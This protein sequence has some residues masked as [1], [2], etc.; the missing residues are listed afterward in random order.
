M[1]RGFA[2]AFALASLVHGAAAAPVGK[3]AVLAAGSRAAAAYDGAAA[4]ATGFGNAKVGNADDA[5]TLGDFGDGNQLTAG[6]SIYNGDKYLNETEDERFPAPAAAPPPDDSA[7]KWLTCANEGELCE[8]LGDNKAKIIRY[9]STGETSMYAD[10]QAWFKEHPQVVKWDYLT[11]EDHED[12]ALCADL[13]FMHRDPFPGHDKVCQCA[14]TAADFEVLPP[15]PPPPPWQKD[16]APSPPPLSPGATPMP[17]PSPDPWGFSWAKC[18]DDGELCTCAPGSMVRYGWTGNEDMYRN[19]S[20]WFKEHPEVVRWVYKDLESRDSSITCSAKEFP[21]PDDPFYGY[22][23]HCQCAESALLTAPEVVIPKKVIPPPAPPA[24]AGEYAPINIDIYLWE[25]CADEGEQCECAAKGVYVRFGSTGEEEMYANGFFKEHPEVRKWDYTTLPRANSSLFCNATAF[26][27]TDPFP[28][29][30]KVCMCADRRPGES[31][32]SAAAAA[33]ANAVASLGLKMKAAPGAVGIAAAA[34]KAKAK[35]LEEAKHAGA[36]RDI[37]A[38][39]AAYVAVL[40]GASDAGVGEAGEPIFEG[41]LTALDISDMQWVYCAEEGGACACPGASALRF[42]NTGEKTM[43]ERAARWFRLHPEV[44]KWAYIRV[45]DSRRD[46]DSAAALTCGTGIVGGDDPFPNHRKMCQCGRTA[47]EAHAHSTALIALGAAQQEE[48]GARAS[49]R[50]SLGAG[51]GAG[52]GVLRRGLAPWVLV[53]GVGA[54]AGVGV[55]LVRRVA[56]R[57]QAAHAERV[58]LCAQGRSEFGTFYGD[59]GI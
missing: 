4:A 48:Q 35:A 17:T 10:N 44:H 16:F 9:G 33:A 32:A 55:F 58:V 23:K 26:E 27:G 20:Q 8:C 52:V 19:D 13:S 34:A 43:Y 7:F 39:A 51:V 30:S 25:K 49:A 3:A 59:R 28:N 54:A 14:Y 46:D 11:L 47:T 2:V 6:G 50:A 38:R 5:G 15:Y 37:A 42:G 29:H 24:P 31:L 57:K 12:V 1:M 53:G 45:S 22:I 21:P 40:G 18:A 56:Q 41:D 36:A